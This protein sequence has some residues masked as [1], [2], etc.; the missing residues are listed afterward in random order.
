MPFGR[1]PGYQPRHG[2]GVHGAR[3]AIC[4]RERSPRNHSVS[5][6]GILFRTG[7]ARVPAPRIWPDV[8]S[9]VTTYQLLNFNHTAASFAGDL[10]NQ[11]LNSRHGHDRQTKAIH[12]F[13]ASERILRSASFIT[14]TA[15]KLVG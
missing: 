6:K 13:L 11:T 3:V 12:T 7:E 5:A 4:Q 15:H 1:K 10:C 8:V 9:R 2:A 14:C